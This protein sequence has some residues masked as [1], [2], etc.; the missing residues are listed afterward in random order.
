MNKVIEFMDHHMIVNVI[1]VVALIVI[2]YWIKNK[3]SSGDNK[4]FVTKK[5]TREGSNLFIDQYLVYMIFS[6]DVTDVAFLKGKHTSTHLD[7]FETYKTLN[8]FI[9]SSNEMYRLLREEIR[10]KNNYLNYSGLFTLFCDERKVEV[11]SSCIPRFFISLNTLAR[12]NNI[13]QLQGVIDDGRILGKDT[14]MRFNERA[15]I[16]RRENYR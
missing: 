1:I 9:H 15:I 2:I 14:F 3:L 16:Q 8:Q 11:E 5:D 10:L 6:H 12:L 7:A 13:K 4:Q